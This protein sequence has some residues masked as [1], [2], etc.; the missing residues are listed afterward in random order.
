MATRIYDA[1]VK[2]GEYTDPTT[3]EVKGRWQN[4]G[5]VMKHEEPGKGDNYFLLLDRTFNPAGLPVK[6]GSTGVLIS[7]FPPKTKG[8]GMG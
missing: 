4:V 2:T 8:E 3:D 1:A 6:E 7:L 5:S